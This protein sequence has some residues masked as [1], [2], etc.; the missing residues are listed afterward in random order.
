MSR[1]TSAGFVGRLLSG[2]V[3]CAIVVGGP[4]LLAGVGSPLPT[5]IPPW[6]RLFTDLRVGYVPTSAIMKIALGAG[7]VFWAFLSYEIAA[8]TS[9]WI[10]HHSSRRSSALGPL[11]V[12]LAKLV[13]SIVLSTPLPARGMATPGALS[14]SNDGI[15]LT[16][17][18]TTVPPA[19]P[20]SDSL[21]LPS[22]VVQPHDTLWGI[23]E[24][25]LG[26][27][28]RWS[29][30]ASLN[31][32]RQEGATTFADPN[33][34]YPGWVLLLPADATVPDASA[35][36]PVPPAGIEGMVP[37][38]SSIE[39][40]GRPI[41]A[42]HA[43]YRRRTAAPSGLSGHLRTRPARSESSSHRAP[44]AA[45]L[46][47]GVHW[48]SVHTI[49]FGVLGGS[50]ILLLD[51][52]RRARQRRLPRG[53]RVSLPE[54]EL[55]GLELGLRRSADVELTL[56]IDLALRLFA[57]VSKDMGA[58]PRLAAV[59]GRPDSVEL[60]LVNAGPPAP[61]FAGDDDGIWLLHRDWVSR[62]GAEEKRSL[63]GM[64]A[65]VP[66]LVT[67]GVDD[68]GATVLV[69]VEMLGSLAV[70]GAEADM[71]LQGMA[72]E[73]C[74]APWA[75]AADVVVVGHRDLDFLERGRSAPSL[76]AVVAETRQRVA[77][78]DR[79]VR[80]GGHV[81]TPH[82]RR[83]RGGE[84]WDPVVVLCLS[85]AVDA[86]PEALVRLVELAGDGN[87]GLVVVAG[88]GV[89]ES[90]ETRWR[91]LA[92]GG[93]I[94][95]TGPNQAPEPGAS[96][97]AVLAETTVRPQAVP[98]TLLAGLDALV[99]AVQCEEGVPVATSIDATVPAGAGPAGGGTNGA[100]DFEVEVRVLGSV[101]VRGNARPFSRAW[102]LELVVYLAMNAG[103]EVST[104]RWCSALWPERLPA[105]AT[106]HSTASAARR[107]LGVSAC[108]VDHLPRS[109][110]RLSLGE[111]VTSDWSRFQQLAGQNTPAS[112]L[113]A[114]RLIRGRP[115]DGL[116]SADWTILEGF[117][118]EIET[119]TVEVA[120]RQAE[121]CLSET[122]DHAG[123]EW[124]ARQAL[125]VNPYD[126]RLY[127][128]LMRAADAAGNPGRVESTMKE[129]VQLVADDVE[130]YDAVHPETMELYRSLSRRPQTRR[131]A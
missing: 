51:R 103:A 7:W 42:D 69:D 27:P 128:I 37:A 102:A 19:P 75:D 33:W 54:A 1:A 18:V 62:L 58:A 77:L 13:A 131:G 130:P 101:D 120:I 95:L 57:S 38:R 108:G 87:H 66:T 78:Q 24:R 22:Y 61:P 65:P 48:T 106:V 105:A 63:K 16:S 49:G 113:G 117:V 112:R 104:D 6:A 94:T 59:R 35:I 60:V 96:A 79:L 34:I 110:G 21:A 44:D 2:A 83:E 97:T 114:L 3:L 68:S 121:W 56:S 98:P 82:A 129:L 9:S 126:E 14:P 109:H 74:T 122:A 88:D 127:R 91:T 76:A 8:E 72:A 119:L 64:E 86:E 47:G 45:R 12:V 124:A 50:V 89:P 52:L 28:L 92:D 29:E 123:A 71:I 116:K 53:V 100:R 125:K 25:C 17:S 84:A 5:E 85:R 73:L 80:Q 20:T 40:S 11:Q 30:I 41:R 70:T 90:V 46:V 43:P 111:S 55:A 15:W 93:S 31:E 23:A 115:F 39:L 107:C 26:D 99:G 67:L 118:A 81:D 32:G 4:I 10:R 36:S